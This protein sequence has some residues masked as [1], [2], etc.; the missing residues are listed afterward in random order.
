MALSSE[1]SV[2]LGSAQ[3]LRFCSDCIDVR[4]APTFRLARVVVHQYPAPDRSNFKP[5]THRDDPDLPEGDLG[6]HTGA[7]GDGRP[8]RVESWYRE[9]H[10]FITCF[11]SVDDLDAASPDHLLEYVRPILKESRVPE[12]RRRLAARDVRTIVDASGHRMFSLTFVVG[13]PRF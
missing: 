7:L 1:R 11:F 5:D 10:T 2:R 3:R 13:E 8:Y 6:A 4:G 9:G 12:E